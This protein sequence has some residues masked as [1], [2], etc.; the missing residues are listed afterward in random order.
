MDDTWLD[1][2]PLGEF[3]EGCPVLRKLDGRRLAC[4]RR[5]DEVHA[6]DDVC[7]HQ[8]YP[9]SQGTA[10]DGVLTCTWHNWKFDL[11]SGECLFG[12]EAVR[13]HPT[14]VEGGRVQLSVAFDPALEESR[15]RAGLAR[16]LRR[17]EVDRALREALRLGE[18]AP[19]PASPALGDLAA[20]FEAIA[21]DGAERAEYGFDHGLALFADLV[22]WT[23]RGWIGGAEAFAAAAHAIAEPSVHLAPREAARAEDAPALDPAGVCEALLEERRDE[24]EARVRAIVRARG[25]RAAVEALLPFLARHF[26][27]YGHSAIFTA[28][29]A[30]IATR[31]PAVAED[32]FG[33][34][35][36]S[37]AWATAE[38]SL[39]PFKA[40][41]SALARLDDLFARPRPGTGEPLAG[42]RRLAYERAVLE[43]ESAA[44][45]ETLEALARG[46]DAMQLLR[47]I[48]HAA[49]ERVARFDSAW[50]WRVDAEVGVLDV[51]HLIT[52]AESAIALAPHAGAQDTAR[53][54]MIAAALVGKLKKGDRDRADDPP[55]RTDAPDLLSAAAARDPGRAIAIARAMDPAERRSAYAMLAPFAAF[56]AATRPIFYAHTVKNTEALCRLDRDDPS[57][58]ATYLV[59]LLG[60]MVPI[61]PELRIRRIAHVARR[62]LADQRPPDGL[63]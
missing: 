56:D 50:E 28:K 58:D 9:L 63:Y 4:V 1:L 42:E 14:R 18:I 8:G 12:G 52:F 19:H 60:Y 49:A 35:A 40:T 26:Y 27:D 23:E 6:I 16:A 34:L 15:L 38:T 47:A 53:L 22:S 46:C 51:T 25:H 37:L 36:A 43:S 41:R 45:G 31:F 62:F 33:A 11:A 20:G 61:R 48:G 29:A 13:R 3:P 54:A 21:R 5:G 10:R 39:P 32:V 2:G 24:A 59:A 44:V 57:A 30:E 7:P 17:D 55:P